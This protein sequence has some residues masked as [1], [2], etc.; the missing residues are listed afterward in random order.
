MCIGLQPL[1][2]GKK[3]NFLLIFKAL[4]QRREFTLGDEK[5]L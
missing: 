1:K 3:M 2:V 4:F 5:E